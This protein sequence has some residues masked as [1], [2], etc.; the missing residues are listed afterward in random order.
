MIWNERPPPWV[1]TTDEYYA[2]T[3]AIGSGALNR[4]HESPESFARY[5]W[6]MAKVS[7]FGPRVDTG[8]PGD[9][10]ALGS[11]VDCLL[12]DPEAFHQRFTR[13]NHKG[14]GVL[15]ITKLSDALYCKSQ[16]IA[17]A[18]RRNSRATDILDRPALRQMCH[19]WTVS[20]LQYRLRADYVTVWFDGL[21]VVVDLKVWGIDISSDWQ[22][23]Q[24]ANRLGAFRQLALYGQGVEHLWGVFPYLFLIIASSKTEGVRVDQLQGALLEKSAAEV[25]A[26]QAALSECFRTGDFRVKQQREFGSFGA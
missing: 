23:R 2:E 9:A 16:R 7:S 24:H 10:I 18:V 22:V 11:A 21:P 3:S 15:G 6:E 25:D 19:K 20:G 12:T 26:D 14:L 4:F 8:Y 1:P 5:M 13:T 17:A